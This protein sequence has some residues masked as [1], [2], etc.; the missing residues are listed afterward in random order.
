MCDKSYQLETL[1]NVDL[2]KYK[3]LLEILGYILAVSIGV[4]LGLIGS[5]GSILTVPILVYLFAVKPQLA[6]TY[7]LFIVGI[8]A[9][10]GSFN[11]YKIGNLQIRSAAVFGFPSILSLL[12]VRKF[13]MPNIPIHLFS[14]LHFDFTKNTLIMLVFAILMV[15]ASI[16][17]IKKQKNTETTFKPKDSKLM[18]IGFSVGIMTGFLGAG[19]GFLIIPSLVFFAG[20]EMK[21]AVGTSLFIIAINALIGFMGDVFIG[22]EIDFQLLI[23]LATL[24]IGGIFIGTYLSKKIDGKKLKPAFG[25]FIMVMGIYIIVKE[26]LLK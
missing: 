26:I 10:I 7:S 8:S 22:V 18:I 13:V 21:K 19:G 1:V 4:S 2:C 17:M 11:Q 3:N 24:S 23:S 16:S 9:M 5:G 14:F 20:L 6:T 25:W 12:L 15:A